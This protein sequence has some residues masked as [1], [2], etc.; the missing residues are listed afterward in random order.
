MCNVWLLRM[1]VKDKQE[2]S[3][4]LESKLWIVG[5]LL[6]GDRGRGS[7]RLLSGT[8]LG[9]LSLLQIRISS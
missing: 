3:S 9:P 2:I 1:D 6:A 7:G 8:C 5:T 4:V